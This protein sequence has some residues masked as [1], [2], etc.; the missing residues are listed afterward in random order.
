M[1]QGKNNL[2]LM[3]AIISIIIV[4]L[5]FSAHAWASDQDRRKAVSK[6]IENITWLKSGSEY[7]NAGIMIKTQG[8]IVYVDPVSLASIDSLPKADIIFVT[9]GHRDHFQR[10]MI[11]ALSNETTK[12]ISTLAVNVNLKSYNPI[13]LKPGEKITVDGIEAKGVP[14]YNRSHIKEALGLGLV[15]TIEGVR[16]YVTG[17]TGLVKEM[18][19]IKSVDICIPYLISPESLSGEDIVELS[20]TIKPIALIPVHWIPGAEKDEKALDLISKNLPAD[21]KMYRLSLK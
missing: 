10:G 7:G 16:I 9:H 3:A 17:S 8:R 13:T 1:N 11:K 6:M 5:T 18:E 19:E 21:T 14:A 12:I 2:A 4:M 15:L 20:K